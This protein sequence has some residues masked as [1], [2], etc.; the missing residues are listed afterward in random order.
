MSSP[1][2]SI[3]DA[4]NPVAVG[5]QISLSSQ[6]TTDRKVRNALF[7]A[8]IV[9]AIAVALGALATLLISVFSDGRSRL[10]WKRVST[11]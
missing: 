6:M 11:Y 3:S 1:A 8:V 10:N 4:T 7:R 9:S 2:E 5:E